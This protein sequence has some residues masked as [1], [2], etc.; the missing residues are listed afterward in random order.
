MKLR[1]LSLLLMIP[2]ISVAGD[3]PKEW[4]LF[5]TDN[6]V[7][8][9]YKYAECDL[10]MGYDHEWVLLKF[11]NTTSTPK[12]VDFDKKMELNGE[13]VTCNDPHGEYHMTVG[14]A[15]NETVEGSCTVYDD[16]SHHIFSKVLTPDTGIDDELTSFDLDNLEVSDRD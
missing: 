1:I 6:G 13:C 15:A 3:E 2:F 11:V 16:P 7:E 9:Y 8:I 12:N 4:T 10:E 14:L 5:A